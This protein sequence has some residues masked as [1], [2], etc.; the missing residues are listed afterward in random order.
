MPI[1]NKTMLSNIHSYSQE[2]YG[3][4][5]DPRAAHPATTITTAL[6]GAA[7]QPHTPPMYDPIMWLVQGYCHDV[8]IYVRPGHPTGRQQPSPQSRWCQRHPWDQEPRSRPG[9]GSSR[10]ETSL[11]D[12]GRSIG[13]TRSQPSQLVDDLDQRL[14]TIFTIL[15]RDWM[16]L[17]Q[18]LNHDKTL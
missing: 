17:V 10:E 15:S 8:A 14:A 16:P 11:D 13:S 9:W 4:C 7:S 1:T 2:S 5:A 6:P 3:N 18:H 12:H